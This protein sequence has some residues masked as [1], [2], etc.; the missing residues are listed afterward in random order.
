[1]KYN[2]F[3]TLQGESPTEKLADLFKRA[4]KLSGVDFI[5]GQTKFNGVH[6]R[7]FGGACFTRRGEKWDLHVLPKFLSPLNEFSV[8]NPELHIHLELF[9]RTVPFEQYVGAVS[10]IN[11]VYNTLADVG[12]YRIF[13]VGTPDVRDYLQ[14][15]MIVGRAGFPIAQIAKLNTPAEAEEFYNIAIANGEEGVVYRIPPCFYANDKAPNPYIYKRVKLHTDEGICEAVGEGKGKRKGMAG[16]LYLRLKNGACLKVGGG[17]GMDNALL[18]KLLA[19][20][21]I[22][23]SVTFS[24]GDV[25][26][27]GMPLRPQYVSVRDYE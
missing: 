3:T 17:E 16:S 21:P 24:Y 19:N 2:N 7:M 25:A 1:M 23:K 4:W 9:S 27:N 20:P 14:R 18:R 5:T 8:R 10:V 15:L 13:D 26:D 22:G 12:E 6:M 11:K